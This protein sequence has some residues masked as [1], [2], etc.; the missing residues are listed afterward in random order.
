MSNVHARI[1]AATAALGLEWSIDADIEPGSVPDRPQ[2]YSRDGRT[3]RPDHI[4]M[5]FRAGVK[6]SG[7][8][9]ITLGSPLVT[10]AASEISLSALT[11]SGCRVLD[12][13]RIGVQR[14]DERFYS[15]AAKAPDWA[16]FIFVATLNTLHGN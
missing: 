8:G 12:G 15:D 3:Y 2:Q 1:T 4:H 14:H 7:A 9:Q 11:V 6:G 13:N 5:V 16:R 10:T